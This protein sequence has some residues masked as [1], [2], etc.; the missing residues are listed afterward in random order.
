MSEP[1]PRSR[2]STLPTLQR[3]LAADVSWGWPSARLLVVTPTDK[4]VTFWIRADGLHY[5][6]I[7]GAGAMGYVEAEGDA[8][9]LLDALRA[10]E[11]V[12]FL[13]TH[14]CGFVAVAGMHFILEPCG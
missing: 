11:W 8:T 5:R 1:S 9:G 3:A 2:P 10:Q 4:G 7:V 12:P 6:L 13:L 14:R